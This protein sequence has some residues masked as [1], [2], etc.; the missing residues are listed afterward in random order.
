MNFKKCTFISFLVVLICFL[1]SCN[2]DENKQPN[3][4]VSSIGNTGIQIAETEYG[5]TR[6]VC[7]NGS[8]VDKIVSGNPHI[9][10][11]VSIDGYY[12]VFNKIAIQKGKYEPKEDL[13]GWSVISMKEDR[14]TTDGII[15]NLF[16]KDVKSM[17]Y[18]FYGHQNI[19]ELKEIPKTIE[20][21]DSAFI[22]CSGLKTVSF[23]SEKLTNANRMFLHCEK[24]ET[25]ENLPDSIVEA[26]S[27]FRYCLSLKGKVY[28]PQNIE[29][30]NNIFEKTENVIRITGSSEKIQYICAAYN[31]VFE[32]RD[33]T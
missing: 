32:Y 25:V 3:I 33:A 27:M 9:G 18:C 20:S 29:Y 31:N 15:E 26:D 23:S 8:S 11:A 28:I 13:D 7:V 6:F 19:K 17:N 14:V 12:Y 4:E 30:F 22:F 5:E 21:A 24:L 1:C 2:K 16:G 10:D